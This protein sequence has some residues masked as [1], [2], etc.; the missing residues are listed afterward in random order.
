MDS[1][2]SSGVALVIS[3]VS[4]PEGDFHICI[5]YNRFPFVIMVEKDELGFVTRKFLI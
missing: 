3:T 2:V 4:I 1:R 5:K